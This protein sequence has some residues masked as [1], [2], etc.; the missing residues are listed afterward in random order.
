[1]LPLDIENQRTDLSIKHAVGQDQAEVQS[2][3]SEPRKPSFKKELIFARWTWPASNSASQFLGKEISALLQLSRGGRLWPGLPLPFG[4][5]F[6]I[7]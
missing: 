4:T 6:T 5:R 1:M 7:H 2:T 3:P